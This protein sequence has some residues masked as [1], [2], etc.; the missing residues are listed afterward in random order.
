MACLMVCVCVCVYVC[1]C[2]VC[3]CVCSTDINECELSEKLC[4]NGQCVNM[5]GR[6][7][8]SCDTGYKS[9]EDRLACVDI[10]E[11]TIQNGG[12]ETFCTNSEGSYECS[13]RSGY[14]LMPDLRTCTGQ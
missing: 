12:C 13:C 4:R 6:Y 10:D 5:I 3:V 9:T 11:C 8:C 1:V 7:Q 2:V 14:A